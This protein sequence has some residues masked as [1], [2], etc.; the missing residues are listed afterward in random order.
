MSKLVRLGLAAG[1]AV[2]V[3]RLVASQKREWQGLTEA[4]M[5][6]K[7]NARIPDRVPL[8]K[9][10][11][12]IDAV[13][14]MRGRD[15]DDAAVVALI[16]ARY[17]AVNDHDWDRFQGFYADSIVWDDPGLAEPIAGPKAV[18]T[19]LELLNRAYPDLRWNLDRIFSRGDLVCAEFTFTGTHE[20]EL[21]GRAA[22]V[23]IEPSGRTVRL[24]GVGVYQ[25][26]DGEIVDSKIYFDFGRLLAD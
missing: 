19:R 11:D 16:E 2:L 23:L 5:R 21:P 6:A 3:A 4:E 9:R 15:I 1:A 18:R 12:I 22:D 24:S 7:L 25:V 20:G 26:K 14:A 17:E 10:R 13:V 8:D